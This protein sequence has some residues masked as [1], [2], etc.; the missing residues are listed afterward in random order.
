VVAG[1]TGDLG[2]PVVE[3]LDVA[4]IHPNRRAA[5]VDRGEYIPGLEVDVGDHRQLG[6]L[7]DGRE[8]VGIVLRGTC[9]PDDVA[10]GGGELGDLLQ[11]GVHVGGDGRGHGLHGDRMLAADPHLADLQLPGRATRRQHRRRPGRHT[12]RD[13]HTGSY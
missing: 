10:A 11:C 9:D 6:V 7:G 3:L 5:R 2:D 4:W 1:L 13:G 8:G 12:Q